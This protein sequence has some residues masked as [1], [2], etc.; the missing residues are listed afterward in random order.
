[1]KDD[2]KYWLD[3][4]G[5]RRW[6]HKT[7][8]YELSRSYHWID[9]VCLLENSNPSSG[10]PYIG[11]CSFTSLES[12]SITTFKGELNLDLNDFEIIDKKYERRKKLEKI[13]K[14]KLDK[15]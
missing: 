7:L 13:M 6:Q 10:R 3:E 12:F 15:Y 1:M 11:E 4:F 9:K 2:K 5:L 8:P 14:K